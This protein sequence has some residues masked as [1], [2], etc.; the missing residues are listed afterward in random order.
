MEQWYCFKDK[1]K[2]VAGDV[3]MIYLKFTNPVEGI[4]CP[5]CGATYL[6][7][8]TVIEKVAK[9]EQMMESK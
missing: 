9:G 8:E 7:E 4:K 6:L 1:E 3:E 5:Q 2:M